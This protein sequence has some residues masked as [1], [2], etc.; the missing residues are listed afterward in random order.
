[1]CALCFEGPDYLWAAMLLGDRHRCPPAPL[2]PSPCHQESWDRCPRILRHSL[3]CHR[4]GGQP[5]SLMWVTG[6]HP[7]QLM[8]AKPK[9]A[10]PADRSGHQSLPLLGNT[11]HHLHGD[12]PSKATPPCKQPSLVWKGLPAAP[13]DRPWGCPLSQSNLLHFQNQHSPWVFEPLASYLI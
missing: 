12:E 6:W 1:M 11:V 3:I 13:W 5:H 10:E 9:P 8:G 2:P 4:K 7:R